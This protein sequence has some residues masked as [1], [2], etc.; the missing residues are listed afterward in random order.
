MTKNEKNSRRKLLNRIRVSGFAAI[1]AALYLDTHP[2]DREALA[3]LAGYC[4]DKKAAVDEYEAEYGPLT[5]CSCS[6]HNGCCRVGN[7]LER[8]GYFAWATTP[9]PWEPEDC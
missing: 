4:A 6:A 5:F 9:W 2:N 8:D 1:E 3:A 7:G